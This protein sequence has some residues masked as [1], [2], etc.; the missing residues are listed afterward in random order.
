MIKK[1]G[2]SV[3]RVRTLVSFF[4]FA[5]IALFP[6]GNTEPAVYHRER[7]IFFRLGNKVQERFWQQ[8]AH[9]VHEQHELVEEGEAA[10]KM[11]S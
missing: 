5:A 1:R 8:K 7:D 10:L 9:I 11:A 2:W 4:A 6:R 3:V